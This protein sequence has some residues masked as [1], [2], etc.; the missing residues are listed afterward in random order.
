MNGDNLNYL[1]SEIS[2]TLRSKNRKYSK[3]KT[4]ELET[5]NHSKNLSKLVH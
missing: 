1:E 3:A 4:D 5:N 2:T